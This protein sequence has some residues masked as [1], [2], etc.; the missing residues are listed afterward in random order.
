[1]AWIRQW[2]RS[3]GWFCGIDLKD[4]FLHVPIH[5]K[6]RKFLRFKWG[7][8]LLE[9]QVLPFC[10]KCSPVSGKP[11]LLAGNGVSVMCMYSTLFGCCL[12]TIWRQIFCLARLWQLGISSS[13][14]GYLDKF[15]VC[16]R[17]NRHWLLLCAG[18]TFS[19][20]TCLGTG[21]SP[22]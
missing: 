1:M 19:R 12:W 21:T 2:L 17:S 16:F 9:W 5:K 6:F 8:K 11:L 13:L 14:I 7:W 3:G 10:L 18:Q 20:E 15:V 4:A 22:R